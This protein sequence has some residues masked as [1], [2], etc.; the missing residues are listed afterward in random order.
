MSDRNARRHQRARVPL[1]VQYR[2][3]PVGE[4]QTDYTAN[5]SRGGMFIVTDQPREVGSILHIQFVTRDGSRII[6]G[7]GRIVRSVE[8]G[9]GDDRRTGQAIEF[10]DFDEED[11]RFVDALVQRT[12]DEQQHPALRVG[13]RGLVVRNRGDDDPER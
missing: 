1:L 12:L 3:S 13:R 5:L 8:Q 7:R 10:L 2:F 4:Y 11:M 9:E 6:R